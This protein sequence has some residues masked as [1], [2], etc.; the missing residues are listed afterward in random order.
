MK[1]SVGVL[2]HISALPGAY[3][4]GA[5]GKECFDF[6][7]MLATGGFSIWQ[8]LPF[9][10]PDDVN[11]PYKSYSAF[12]VNPAF[13]DLDAL[14]G[15]GLLTLDELEEAR[16]ASAFVCDF[17]KTTK[18]R[19]S[20]LT[21]AANRLYSWENVDNC[22]QKLPDCDQFCRYMAM[23]CYA[24]E[25]G[26]GE[27]FADRIDPQAYRT[28]RFIVYTFLTQW[29]RV[30]TYA[31][32]RGISIVGDIPIYVADES[33]DIF[34]SPEQFQLDEKGH[35]LAVA[36]VPP[37]YFSE[38]GQLWGNP[39]YDWKAMA[40]D[41]FSWWR[42]RMA[43]MCQLFDGVRIDHF[44]AIASYWRIPV[45][46]Q[47]AKAGKWVRGPGMPFVRAMREAAGD[48]F[49]IAEDLGDLTPDVNVLMHRCALPGMRVLQFGFLGDE[50]SP[51]LPHNYP[52]NTVAYTGTHDNNTL[53]GFVWELDDERRA[54]LMDY[55]GYRGTDWNSRAAYD[56]IIRTMYRSHA[57]TLIIPIQDL[58]LYGSDTRMNTPGK[59]KGN[60]AYRTTREQLRSIEWN[61][62]CHLAQ[63]YGR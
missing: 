45:G 47:T 29:Q 19:V 23:R 11:S 17:S 5:F 31:N 24:E 36:G 37:D 55:V 1:R 27:L 18:A 4:S 50:D 21:K 63:L 58:L 42:R 56:A 3:G 26:E 60:W 44:R 34:F 12:S 16:G 25:N 57:K 51:H 38:D 15:E 2:M 54:Q 9:T 52:E 13:I 35:P 30:R 53:L 32:E 61:H 41:N 7:D 49:L 6:I 48:S 62:F 43:F 40:K 8:T 22:L 33:A 10:L 46:A 59:A 20:L 28:W 14:Y 39:L